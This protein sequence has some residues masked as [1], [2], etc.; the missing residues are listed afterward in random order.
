MMKIFKHRI[1][2]LWN[3]TGY[4]SM[5]GEISEEYQKMDTLDLWKLTYNFKW[6]KK[7]IGLSYLWH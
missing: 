3:E 5:A 2:A 7:E 1:S 4:A 6:K